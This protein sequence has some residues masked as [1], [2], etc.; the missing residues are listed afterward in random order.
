MSVQHL[1]FI[2]R[3]K[4]MT[5]TSSPINLG[6]RRMTFLQI[7]AMFNLVKIFAKGLA[8]NY[9]VQKIQSLFVCLPLFFAPLPS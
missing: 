9:K 8:A 7:K 3:K 2:T 5:I 6:H 1:H 4:G